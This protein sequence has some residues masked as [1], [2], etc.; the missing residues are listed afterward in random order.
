MYM[1]QQYE[2]ILK[3][4]PYTAQELVRQYAKILNPPKQKKAQFS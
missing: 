4:D 2:N 1:N 3:M